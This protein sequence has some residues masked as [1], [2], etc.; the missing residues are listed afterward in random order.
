MKINLDKLFDTFKVETVHSEM[1]M[2]YK[3]L[4]K[5]KQLKENSKIIKEV[6]SYIFG[7]NDVHIQ[8]IFVKYLT[9]DF[10]NSLYE[11]CLA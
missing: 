7:L 8:K 5:Q 6:F 10:N 2:Y 3:S 4:Y 9:A 1:I 11:N